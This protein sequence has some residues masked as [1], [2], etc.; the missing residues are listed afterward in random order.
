[1]DSEV[2]LSD[3]IESLNVCVCVC[4]GYDVQVGT[5]LRFLSRRWKATV[6]DMDGKFNQIAKRS[7]TISVI[8]FI[9]Y[10]LRNAEDKI[11][12]RC[13]CSSVRSIKSLSKSYY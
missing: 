4:G 6:S 2:L 3:T 9:S 5:S 12:D 10:Q 7:Y 13:Y 1:M 11:F 8:S